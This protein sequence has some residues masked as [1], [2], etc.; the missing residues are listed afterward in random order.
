MYEQQQHHGAV[1]R[2]V[3]GKK[4]HSQ[5][6]SCPELTCRSQARLLQSLSISLCL[7]EAATGLSPGCRE[8]TSW[9][10]LLLLPGVTRGQLGIS[11]E[12]MT[13]A[14]LCPAPVWQVCQ[15]WLEGTAT[16]MLS[17]QGSHRGKREKGE[18]KFR[19]SEL[20]KSLM[21][22]PKPY[23]GYYAN[24]GGASC[25]VTSDGFHGCSGDPEERS[26]GLFSMLGCS[27]PDT[28]GI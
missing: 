13:R 1:P 9:P 23:F 24:G 6:P 22:L 8:S 12:T 26:H 28:P 15:R 20:G 2:G 27:C 18:E 7:G 17:E 19:K 21:Q 14:S 16:R 3:K 10:S 4:G 11:R 25:S 5:V